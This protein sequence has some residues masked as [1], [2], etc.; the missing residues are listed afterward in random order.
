[1]LWTCLGGGGQKVT[2]ISYPLFGGKRGAGDGNKKR[3]PLHAL[4]GYPGHRKPMIEHMEFDRTVLVGS[5]LGNSHKQ[6]G[7][8]Q[9]DGKSYAWTFG[10]LNGIF[11]N[12]HMAIVLEQS[13]CKTR[14]SCFIQSVQ[15]LFRARAPPKQIN[16]KNTTEQPQQQAVFLG[17][18]SFSFLF[19]A[20]PTMD[21]C[22]LKLRHH[23]LLRHFSQ[24][25]PALPGDEIDVRE[26]Q[27]SI[28]SESPLCLSP[29]NS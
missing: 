23:T 25:L 26:L 27:A 6:D 11:I 13:T 8:F 1:M 16:K 21:P 7:Y 15:W 12:Q 2:C 14:S 20:Y 18:F 24:E 28:A 10:A 5:P 3:L 19:K 4:E 17:G 22:R 9:I 29:P